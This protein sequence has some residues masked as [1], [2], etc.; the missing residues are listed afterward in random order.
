[1]ILEMLRDIRSEMSSVK[2]MV[3]DTERGIIN[4]KKVIEERLKEVEL[5]KKSLDKFDPNADVDKETND[6]VAKLF[7]NK[8][9]NNISIYNG[10]ISFLTNDIHCE[11]KKIVYNIGKFEIKLGF[12]YDGARSI[13]I[14]NL[15][16]KVRGYQERMNAPH[17][18][19]DGKPCLGN[20]EAV[21]KD[22]YANGRYD[23][24]LNFILDYLESVNV[25]DSAGA[26]I[27]KWPVVGKEKDAN[28]DYVTFL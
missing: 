7:S 24:V 14:N 13:N 26:H 10:G 28:P 6:V 23:L 21:V 11:H 27:N 3:D 1:M 2:L 9:V 22:L 20:A 5:I 16:W 12:N 19:S 18:F 17:V 4:N 25:D 8:K 15:K